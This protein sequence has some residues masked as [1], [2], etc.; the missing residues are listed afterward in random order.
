MWFTPNSSL[1]EWVRSTRYHCITYTHITSLK[2]SATLPIVKLRLSLLQTLHIQ[3]HFRDS[4]YKA[5]ARRMIL[6][7]QSI[8]V[9]AIKGE[10]CDYENISYPSALLDHLKGHSFNVQHLVTGQNVRAYVQAGLPLSFL[11][12]RPL[13]YV[14][15]GVYFGAYGTPGVSI[16]G[17]FRTPSLPIFGI[18]FGLLEA[19]RMLKISGNLWN[20]GSTS[21]SM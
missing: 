16:F 4:F 17:V 20:S 9:I 21:V 14:R 18:I 1:H 5:E 13:A 6:L 15:Q 11:K 10:N 19:T 8:K 12:N 2:S 3:S 7:K